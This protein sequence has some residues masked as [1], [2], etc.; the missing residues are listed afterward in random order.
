MVAAEAGKL[1]CWF[2]PGDPDSQDDTALRTTANVRWAAPTGYMYSLASP[3]VSQGRIILGADN[4]F[5]LDLATG[6]L[7]WRYP[8]KLITAG[9]GFASTATIEN[10][11]VYVLDSAGKVLCLDLYR[12]RK[13]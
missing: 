12:K 2:S 3:V 1:P 8:K 5:C 11:R 13:E 7:L 4:L 10:D 6:T 9:W